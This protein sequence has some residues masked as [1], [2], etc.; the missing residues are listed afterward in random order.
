[1]HNERKTGR[2][3]ERVKESDQLTEPR[4]AMER[5]RER[6]KKREKGRINQ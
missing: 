4:D 1:M 3:E 6:K 5:E 2:K